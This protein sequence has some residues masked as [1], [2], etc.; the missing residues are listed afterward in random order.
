MPTFLKIVLVMGAFLVTASVFAENSVKASNG[1][2]YELEPVHTPPT[3]VIWLRKNELIVTDQQKCSVDPKSFFYSTWKC[4][5]S[6]RVWEE[7]GAVM[8]AVREANEREHIRPET[9]F[10][11][12][13]MVSLLCLM[14]SIKQGWKNC[15]QLFGLVAACSG[16]GAGLCYSA[17]FWLGFIQIL[18]SVMTPV[19][20]S[21]AVGIAGASG[22][23][24]LSFILGSV[25]G[26]F[27]VTI[28]LLVV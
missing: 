6:E 14:L 15:V 20:C 7:R 10:P 18:L 4:D 25:Y 24:T 12:V 19:V 16:A 26:L 13:A 5:A 21:A 27:L 1:I 11:V 3:G 9:L 2:T 8:K 28:L 23:R 17:V 22:R